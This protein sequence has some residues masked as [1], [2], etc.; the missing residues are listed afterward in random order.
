MLLWITNM[1][2]CRGMLLILSSTS[3]RTSY[4]GA[5]SATQTDSRRA[6]KLGCPT[7]PTTV[8]ISSSDYS[9]ESPALPL[10]AERGALEVRC[11]PPTSQVSGRKKQKRVDVLHLLSVRSASVKR[12]GR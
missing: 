6:G 10:D 4:V 7:S 1:L 8:L 11:T 9:L 12:F 2:A 5:H 3:W